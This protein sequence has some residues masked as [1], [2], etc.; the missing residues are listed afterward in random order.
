[1]SRP[2]SDDWSHMIRDQ[3]CTCVATQNYKSRPKIRTRFFRVREKMFKIRTSVGDG[4]VGTDANVEGDLIGQL[5]WYF[6]IWRCLC[7]WVET[8]Y[9]PLQVIMTVL[10]Q[11]QYIR[12]VRS[13][14]SFQSNISCF[15]QFETANWYTPSLWE[16]TSECISV[17]VTGKIF[18]RMPRFST[19]WPL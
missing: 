17:G 10:G 12:C 7:K 2:T 13:G 9:F 1:M 3:R 5:Q 6:C 14:I 11:A 15:E 19:D 18:H 8:G 4:Y 16:Y